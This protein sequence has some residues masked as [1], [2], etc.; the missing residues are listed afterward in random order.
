VT[1]NPRIRT[2][3][4][5]RL[6][7]I[8]ALRGLSALAVFVSHAAEA[9][10]PRLRE[11][12]HTSFDLGHFGVVLFFLCS[13]FVIPMSFERQP[14]LRTFWVRRV[15]RL[16]PLYWFTM[17]LSVSLAYSGSEH[18]SLASFFAANGTL[19]LAN[20]TMLE[21]FLGYPY[22]RAEYWT[23]MFEMLFYVVVTLLFALKIIKR[24]ALF[25]IGLMLAAIV[26][27]GVVP[28]AYGTSVPSGILSFLA[29]MFLGMWF[30]RFSQGQVGRR[31]TVNIGV[32]GLVMIIVT[33]LPELTRSVGGQLHVQAMTARLGASGVFGAAFLLR[34]YRPPR[35][36]LYLGTI[37]YSLYL[38]QTYIMIPRFGSPSLTATLWLASLI[39]VASATYRWIERPG[40]ALGRSLT[41][42][43]TATDSQ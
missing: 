33:T 2:Q 23:L 7:F 19:I 43:K 36:M 16:Y 37:S 14:S 35:F 1:E 3:A 28:L 5:G 32:L 27:E 26:V 42:P 10:S 31:A 11:Y 25:T 29:I 17:I 12:V 30:Y 21:L 15:C 22:I 13:G 38:M 20:L 6:E 41:R 24:T 8:D 18:H 40:I 4:D 39:A 34:G 9:L